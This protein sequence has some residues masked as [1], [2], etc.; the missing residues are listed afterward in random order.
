MPTTTAA[1]GCKIHYERS[2]SGPPVVLIP[3]LGGD[4]RF[5]YGVV[6]RLADRFDL[7]VMDHRGAG[8]SDRPDKPYSIGIIAKDLLS[9]LNAERIEAAHLVGH[10]TGGAIVQ[11]LA[12]DAPARARR[13]VIS[14]SWDR[15]DARFRALFEARAALLDAGLSGPYQLL[16]HVFGFDPAWMES[17][18]AELNRAVD[19]AGETLAP[20]S[21]TAARVRMLLD[22][23]R[24][25]EL[26]RV[27]HETLVIGA[28]GD[29]LIPF[30]YAERL[31]ARLTG[32]EMVRLEEAH[33]HPSIDP[34]PFAD[35]VASFLQRTA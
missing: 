18:E 8:R 15:P 1:D 19:V 16:T 7:I 23:D 27:R 9:V 30:H 29:M 5:W 10:S 35:A 13:L 34:I 2:G 12:L 6:S 32:A 17:H 24:S 21:V 31:A 4:G 3:G 22:F 11:T 26:A 25:A 14:G 33:F 20:L 28:A